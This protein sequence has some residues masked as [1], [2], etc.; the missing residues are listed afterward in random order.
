[1][2][3][4]K[5]KLQGYII[6]LIIF[7]SISQ[8]CYLNLKSNN[9]NLSNNTSLKSIERDNR[10]KINPSDMGPYT[11]QWLENPNFDSPIE[12]T[13]YSQKGGDTS[14]VEAT[15]S[16]GQG[17]FN[18]LGEKNNF[19]V[20]ADPSKDTEWRVGPSSTLPDNYE[21]NSSG[22]FVSH[23]W[24][25]PESD[26]IA[27]IQWDRNVTL[28]TNMLD[29][30]IT[31]ASV[32][33]IFNATVTSSPGPSGGI[34]CPGDTVNQSV[35]YDYA[36]FYVLISDLEKNVEIE[37]AYN[38]TIDL[39]KD[40]AGLKDYLLDTLMT[41]RAENELIFYLNKVLEYDY[42]NFTIS[43]GIIINSEDNFNGTINDNDYWD[44]LI[45]KSL[46]LTFTY[47]K[48][49]DSSTFASWNQ[50]G[51]KISDL[52]TNS[53]I[54][55]NVSLNF[56][57][58]IDKNWTIFTSSQN[59]EINIHLNG[60]PY[61]IPIKLSEINTTFDEI[62]FYLVLPTD[63]VNISIQVLIKDNFDLDQN[64]TISIDD[65][66]LFISYIIVE[67]EIKI[68]SPNNYDVYRDKA[69]NFTIEIPYLHLYTIWYTIN[70]SEIKYFI[71]TNGT[72]N[73]SAWSIL[74]E[75]MVI[76]KFFINDTKGN[77]ANAEIIVE[78]EIIEVVSP[79]EGQN[80]GREAPDFVVI[81]TLP[82]LNTTWYIIDGV[83]MIFVFKTNST[84]NQ[85]AWETVWDP[86]SHQEVITIIFYANDT[87]GN[88][89]FEKVYVKKYDPLTSSTNSGNGRDGKSGEDTIPGYDIFILI[90]TI[91]AVLIFFIKNRK[92]SHF[93]I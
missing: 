1:M 89:I 87:M 62:T 35:T 66:Y 21:V 72:I 84:I 85:T 60:N 15:T 81:I 43:L 36:Y 18:V 54:V 26:Q 73:Q 69:P 65:V 6:L 55:K 42:Q 4:K 67:P 59:S 19:S 68:I 53:V 13:W 74:P 11:E 10:E 75:G 34:E 88:V 92:K 71:F 58:K 78:K 91:C 2:K 17:N 77:N 33:A 8:I 7:S 24:E 50:D 82:N 25:E 32:N 90:G 86:L 39:G 9:I 64:I 52:S 49:V 27:Y 93:K 37:I 76:I 79:V 3:Q 48:M 61:P 38:R 51:D 57:C 63:S 23:S 45:I 31:Q 12:P 22:F 28:P 40:S 5:I 20:I 47:E 70:S 30:N 16:P 44:A 41:T 80:I 46:N 14:D 83:E 56:K 29:Y